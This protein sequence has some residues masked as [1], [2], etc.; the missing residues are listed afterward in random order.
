MCS[1][2]WWKEPS[3]VECGAVVDSCALDLGSYEELRES[4]Q[5]QCKP[6]LLLSFGH[7]MFCVQIGARVCVHAQAMCC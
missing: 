2:E 7:S 4:G 5:R 1:C 6:K 3:A